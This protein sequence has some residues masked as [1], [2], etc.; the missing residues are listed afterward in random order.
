MNPETLKDSVGL[1]PFNEGRVLLVKNT[2][3][4]GYREEIYGAPA[5]RLEEGETEKQAAVREFFEETGLTTTEDDLEDFENNCYSAE[6]DRKEGK[7]VYSIRFLRVKNFEGEL[8]ASEATIPEWVELGQARE[9]K[10]VANVKEAIE[11]AL[12]A[13]RRESESSKPKIS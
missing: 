12:H 7:K 2:L 6:L 10:L 8:K 5:G 3:K 9:M 11:A 4:S 1:R 13:I